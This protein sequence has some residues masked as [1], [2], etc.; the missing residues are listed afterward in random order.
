MPWTFSL[1][2]CS[3]AFQTLRLELL[4]GRYP[5][6]HP[7]ESGLSSQKLHKR[8]SGF[9]AI[10]HKTELAEVLTQVAMDLNALKSIGFGGR[11]S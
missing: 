4:E 5:L 3:S 11:L 6:R 10:I 9:Q 2:H 8:A 1:F 7:T